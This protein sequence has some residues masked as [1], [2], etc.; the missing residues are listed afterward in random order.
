MPA[1]SASKSLLPE[2]NKPATAQKSPT[3]TVQFTCSRTTN[4]ASRKAA[5]V[6][7]RISNAGTITSVVGEVGVD[8]AIIRPAGRRR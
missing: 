4:E 1:A 3:S 7:L 5:T 2:R 6:T 8:A